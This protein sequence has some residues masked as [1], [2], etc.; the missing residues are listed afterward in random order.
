MK[1]STRLPML[2]LVCSSAFLML[3]LWLAVG[4]SPA[5]AEP[6]S[7]L[8]HPSRLTTSMSRLLQDRLPAENLAPLAY[9]PCVN[10]FAGNY[11][12]KKVDLLSFMPLTSIGG[13]E[14]NTVWGWTDPQT[15]KEYAIVGRVSGTS[16]VDI[17]DPVNP[18]YVGNLP[19]HTT[20]SIWREL[21]VY[22][23]HV[24]VVSEASN[25]GM[26]VF[27][28]TR[29][30][31]VT[32]PPVT[33]TENAHY[34]QIGSAHNIAINEET[35]VAYVVGA[36][37]CNGGLH[38]VNIQ[39]P[40]S[41]TF[42]GCFDD[43]GYTHDTQCVIYNG[44]DTTHQGQE[45]CLNAN[46]DTL[47]IVDVT[48]KANPTQ[49]S[50]TSYTGVG[51]THQG[52]LTEDQQ[53]FLLD[54]ELDEQGNGYNTRTYIWDVRDLDNPQVI[55]VFTGPTAAIDHNQY[56]KE[57][58]TYQANYR[59]GLRILDIQQAAEGELNEVGYFDIYPLNNNASF[60]GAW[61]VYPYFESGVVV[62][63]GIEQ[64][65]FVLLPQPAAAFTTTLSTNPHECGPDKNIVLPEGGGAVTFCY[66][67]SNDGLLDLTHHTLEDSE[68][69]ILLNNLAYNLEYDTSYWFT[70]TV[71]ITETATHLL[72]WTGSLGDFSAV[73]TSTNTILVSEY[74]V[75][76]SDDQSQAGY[77]G[78]TLTYTLV[79]TNLGNVTDTFDL[80]SEANWPVTFAT[81]SL[82][83]GAGLSA[84]LDV[85]VS[86]PLTETMP[87]TDTAVITAAS[88]ANP[89]LFATTTLHS[90]GE[91]AFFPA[92]LPLVYRP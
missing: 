44:P 23:N 21:K 29:L 43:D 33:F 92:Y 25:H 50:R 73:A 41:P 37:A 82:T 70:Q 58:L 48:N 76:L 80:T 32:N 17:S 64:G 89:T 87:L 22:N 4:G 30:R 14:L 60:N 11:P 69:G 85:V 74:G 88:Q 51:Y 3:G 42:L 45:I 49:L 61:N 12:C 20:N 5:A 26:Q 28:L 91:R 55:G 6:E 15:G 35:G 62:V 54:D 40:T 78:R 27:D 8:P 36:A 16:F 57:N 18:I 83:L 52:W 46:E 71:E 86:L 72:T 24:F 56:I 38:M 19:P 31:S 65:L 53:Y 66:Q 9:T 13:S 81:N 75:A 39:N 63:S 90:F 59:A 77:Y 34:N 47:T 7:E 79:I 1:L 2:L 67:V 68:R 10:G 84:H